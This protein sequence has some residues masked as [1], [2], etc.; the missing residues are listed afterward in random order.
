MRKNNICLINVFNYRY[1][2][3]TVTHIF[4][5]DNITNKKKY[6]LSFF[7][8]S[9]DICKTVKFSKYNLIKYIFVTGILANNILSLEAKSSIFE[10]I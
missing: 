1:A 4:S 2:C 8:M 7:A 6:F 5:L 10:D 3:N 9:V